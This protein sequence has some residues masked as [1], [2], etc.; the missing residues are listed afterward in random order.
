MLRAVP[1]DY[2]Q[3]NLT[4]INRLCL[5]HFKYIDVVCKLVFAH[6]RMLLGEFPK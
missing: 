2:P 1:H 3:R 5:R 4:K 6:I